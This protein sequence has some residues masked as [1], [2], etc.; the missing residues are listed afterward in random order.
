MEPPGRKVFDDM[1]CRFDGDHVC[2]E[3]TD[4]RTDRTA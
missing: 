4:R 2:D 1:F 3:Q